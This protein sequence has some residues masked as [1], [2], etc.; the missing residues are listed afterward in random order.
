MITT[1]QLMMNQIMEEVL[2]LWDQAG[3]FP[4]LRLLLQLVQMA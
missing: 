4:S 2:L 3:C 1:P